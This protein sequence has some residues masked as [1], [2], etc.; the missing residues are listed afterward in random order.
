MN[1]NPITRHHDS[2][3]QKIDQKL[4]TALAYREFLWIAR[5]KYDDGSYLVRMSEA[6]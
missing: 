4:E 1:E 3:P 5:V 2:P 6:K